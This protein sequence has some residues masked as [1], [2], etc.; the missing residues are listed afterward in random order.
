MELFLPLKSIIKKAYL[1]CVSTL[2]FLLSERN[3]YAVYLPIFFIVSI[4]IPI[5]I[6]LRSDF[7]ILFGIFGLTVLGSFIKNKPLYI[8]KTVGLIAIIILLH[9]LSTII[10]YFY[11]ESRLATFGFGSITEIQ[12]WV[13]L[14]IIIIICRNSDFNLQK[15]KNLWKKFY[16]VSIGIIFI[17]LL[18]S[19]SLLPSFYDLLIDKFFASS[20]YNL[21]REGLL[22]ADVRRASSI[23]GSPSIYAHFCLLMFWFTLKMPKYFI[24]SST[25]YILLAI[26]LASGFASDSKIFYA[27][28]LIV[29]FY[30][31]FILKRNFYALIGIVFFIWLLMFIVLNADKSA[32]PGFLYNIRSKIDLIR[33]HGFMNVFFSSRFDSKD[34]LLFDSLLLIKDNLFFG[35]G[36]LKLNN[37][38]FGD[39]FIITNFLKIG[40]VGFSVFLILVRVLY[41]RLNKVF[42]ESQDLLLKNIVLVLRNFLILNLIF[43]IGINSFALTRT[44]DLIFFI[45]FSTIYVHQSESKKLV[46]HN[47]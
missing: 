27:G 33:I 18:E 24:S 7:F 44:S 45:M 19:F 6:E 40:A 46:N 10:F 22:N 17:G 31:Q 8:D 14:I 11:G 21:M 37:L 16:F 9:F 38:F 12:F 15:F 39:S 20:K 5:G 36:L 4:Y 41:I 35:I 1:L 34:G 3:K 13:R 42:K 43:S 28:F 25:K 23:L 32:L 47:I 26:I 29:V 30:E 2:S